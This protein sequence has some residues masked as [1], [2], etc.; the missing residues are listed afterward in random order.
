MESRKPRASVRVF[1]ATLMLPKTLRLTTRKPLRAATA[2]AGAGAGTGVVDTGTTPVERPGAEGRGRGLDSRAGWDTGAGT[3]A[4]TGATAWA[5]GGDAGMGD[6][7]GRRCWF[8][9]RP[10]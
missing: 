5:A 3:G 7:A 6:G 8:S 2:G 1:P 4:G 9:V 10:F